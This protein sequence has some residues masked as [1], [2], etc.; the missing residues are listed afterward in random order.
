MRTITLPSKMNLDYNLKELE[1]ELQIYE[2]KNVTLRNDVKG[3][4]YDSIKAHLY[5]DAKSIEID[6]YKKR[7]LSEEQKNEIWN[8]FRKHGSTASYYAKKYRKTVNSIKYLLDNKMQ[9]KLK[10]RDT[11]N[12]RY[13]INEMQSPSYLQRL[14]FAKELGFDSISDACHSFGEPTMFIQKFNKKYG[15]PN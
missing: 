2:C 6:Q 4:D 9:G 11:K 13:F 3:V 15:I 5:I 14:E 10:T 12:E 7:Y 8:H 1:E